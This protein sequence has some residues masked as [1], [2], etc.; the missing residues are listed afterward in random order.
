MVLLSATLNFHQ[1]FSVNVISQSVLQ[2]CSW[3]CHAV[4]QWWTTVLFCRNYWWLADQILVSYCGS[5]TAE[6]TSEKYI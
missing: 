3:N 2:S 5:S 6:G 4:L 1:Y